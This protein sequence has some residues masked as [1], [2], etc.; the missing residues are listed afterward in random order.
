MR[1]LEGAPASQ[2][3]LVSIAKSDNDTG[4]V[5]NPT[6]RASNTEG[7]LRLFHHILKGIENNPKARKF[8]L[9]P[10][11]D[12]RRHHIS[13]D[14][15]AARLLLKR[16]T[17]APACRTDEETCDE[18]ICDEEIWRSLF[19]L[20][21]TSL[22]RKF[23]RFVTTNGIA[24][25]IVEEVQSSEP[26][27]QSYTEEKHRTRA[28][29]T[30]PDRLE[31]LRQKVDSG[32]FHLV[33]IDPGANNL[34]TAVITNKLNGKTHTLHLSKFGFFRGGGVD[35]SNKR[36]KKWS[37]ALQP[38]WNNMSLNS[39]K[40]TNITTWDAHLKHLS[41]TSDGPSPWERLW[42]EKLKPRWANE[43]FRRYCLKR[44]HVMSFFQNL[45]DILGCRRDEVVIAIGSAGWASSSKGSISG[46]QVWLR[47]QLQSF[48]KN[49]VFINEFRT[50][51]LCYLCAQEGLGQKLGSVSAIKSE[52]TEPVDLRGLKFCSKHQ[53]KNRDGNAAQ[54]I[55]QGFLQMKFQT[56]D[57]GTVKLQ[58]D[59]RQRYF[60]RT[61][62]V[63]K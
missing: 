49:V 2:P 34:Y 54:N 56:S 4:V 1:V 29:K 52:E 62:P 14:N 43:E 51:M 25:S 13:I 42:A 24:L 45:V 58:K 5:M 60:T 38:I 50:S 17:G 10:V 28:Q 22:H 41:T 40:T 30:P 36:T 9:C 20:K 15:K 39:T 6:W 7:L 57:N 11:A 55:G 26:Q 18:E 8:H 12:I 35:K 3:K 37:E 53:F 31:E 21:K 63:S 16:V 48:F 61:F 46:P 23:T 27:K 44:K 32:E 59:Y 33:T 47:D 19:Y